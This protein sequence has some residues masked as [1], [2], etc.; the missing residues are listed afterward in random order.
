[1]I[2]FTKPGHSDDYDVMVAGAVPAAL[3]DARKGNPS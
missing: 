2:P 1:M 3:P